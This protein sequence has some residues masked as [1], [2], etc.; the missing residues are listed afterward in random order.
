VKAWKAA[1]AAAIATA[2]IALIVIAPM[3]QSSKSHGGLKV[4]TVDESTFSGRAVAKCPRGYV[5]IGGGLG[6]GP[7]EVILNAVKRTP[8][9]WEVDTDFSGS[10][11]KRGGPTARAQAI[12]AKGTGGFHVKDKG[13]L[14]G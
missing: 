7:S 1:L 3:A 4:T 12:C 11:N 10:I 13:E 9:K 14:G 8:R 6:T 5:V 2:A